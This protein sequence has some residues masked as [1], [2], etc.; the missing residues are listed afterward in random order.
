M[1]NETV[2]LLR[3]LVDSSIEITDELCG[4]PLPV[5]VNRS[6][7]E[8]LLLNLA[9]NA[10]DAMPEGGNLII[11]TTKTDS[12]DEPQARLLVE[13]TGVGIAP[14]AL[15]QIFD[16]FYTTKEPGKGTGLGLVTVRRI[17][18]AARGEVGVRSEPGVGTAFTVTLP[19]DRRGGPA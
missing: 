5:L 4:E 7:I 12:H 14:A 6:Q 10:R 15:A 1:A 2:R 11:R 16:P 18:T 19:L 13:D 8:Q 17:V 3:R 9:V